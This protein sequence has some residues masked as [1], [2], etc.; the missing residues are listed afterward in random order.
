[1]TSTP[2][3]SDSETARSGT[4]RPARFSIAASTWGSKFSCKRRAYRVHVDATEVD[5]P[6]GVERIDR[7]NDAGLAEN[8]AF[9]RAIATGDRS[10][11]LSD[12][13]DALRTQRVVLAANR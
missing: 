8:V 9:L 3:I 2:S 7:S 4:F 11:I 10:G 5:T 13:D 1:M 12:Y 6:D